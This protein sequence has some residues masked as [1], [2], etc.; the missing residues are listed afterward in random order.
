MIKKVSPSQSDFSRAL[1]ELTNKNTPKV[2][3][4]CGANDGLHRS[5]GLF[6]EKKKGWDV[7]NVEP[8]KEC[9]EALTKNRPESNNCN[10]ALSDETSIR[11]MTVP[12][13]QQRGFMGGNGSIH[14]PRMRELVGSGNTTVHYPVRCITYGELLKH[15][16]IESVGILVLDVEGHEIS[17]LRGMTGLSTNTPEIIAIEYKGDNRDVLTDALAKVGDYTLAR[18]F[19]RHDLVYVKKEQDD[20]K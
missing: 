7:I 4:E 2:I 18:M 14:Q 19:T 1:Y 9:F 20:N 15:C 3:I 5:I 6:F 12:L 10:Y 17:V 13:S 16:N 11:T 8:N